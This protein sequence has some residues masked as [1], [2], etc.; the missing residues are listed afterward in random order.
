MLTPATPTALTPETLAE[1]TSKLHLLDPQEQK[2]LLRDM[3]AYEERLLLQQQRDDFLSFC[4]AVYPDWKEIG[5][6]H[7]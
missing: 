7:V 1:L 2:A 3:E 6:A 5:R 4:A